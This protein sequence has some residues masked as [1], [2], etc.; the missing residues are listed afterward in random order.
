MQA[1][2]GQPVPGEPGVIYCYDPANPYKGSHGYPYNYKVWAYSAD[3]LLSV[4]AGQKEPWELVPYAM[5][6]FDL[7]FASGS[8][9]LAG[10][11][12]DPATQRVFLAQANGDGPRPV[13]HVFSVTPP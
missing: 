6:N 10:V 5:W 3:D 12:Y 13:V 9:D 8:R 7:P 4:K 11:S 2:D 1:L